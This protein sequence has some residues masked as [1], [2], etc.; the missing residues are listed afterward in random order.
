MILADRLISRSCRALSSMIGTRLPGG[1]AYRGA[2]EDE[3]ARRRMP[4]VTPLPSRRFPYSPNSIPSLRMSCGD[5]FLS[6][7]E[8]T[9]RPHEA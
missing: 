1:G 7:F 5:G 3:A 2:H 6:S 8:N 9:R 4:T